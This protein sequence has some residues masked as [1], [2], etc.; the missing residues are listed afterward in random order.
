MTRRLLVG[1]LLLLA[2][3]LPAVVAA[4]APASDLPI[5]PE[6]APFRSSGRTLVVSPDGPYRSPS[7]ALAAA[8]SGDT[9]EV[10]GGT[11][12]EH[13]EVK[14]AIRLVGV[15]W[16][17]LDGGGRGS[18]LTLLAPRVE[19]TGFQIRGTGD[20]PSTEDAA[21]TV[22]APGASIHENRI[23]EA[24]FGIYLRQADHSQVIGNEITGM[25]VDLGLRGDAI[26]LWYSPV[27]TVANNRVEGGRDVI[28]WFSDQAVVRENT[29]SHS[30]YGLHFMWS[31]DGT[32]EGNRLEENSV[33][34]FVMYSSRVV[35]RQ[36]L[37][38]E[39]RG[40]SGYGLALKDSEHLTVEQNWIAGNRVGLYLDN[41]PYS[42]DASNRFTL[43]V[44]AG[45]EVGLLAMP[46][47]HDNQFA[48]NDFI[49]NA[50]QVQLTTGG[51][52]GPNTWAE[53]GLG[54]FWSDYA[55]YDGNGD[56][57]GD[58]PYQ[59]VS[60]FDELV[61]HQELLRWFRHSPAA[62]AVDLAARA[63]P[64]VAPEP[65]LTDPAPSVS[66]YRA[67]GYLP[68]DTATDSRGPSLAVVSGGMLGA[69]AL[70]GAALLRAGPHRRRGVAR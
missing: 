68:S 69:A 61:S 58:M 14:V 44:V 9:V 53:E 17:V 26:R 25:K 24:L 66:P 60:L 4:A 18:V 8:G 7:A 40:P 29:I 31:G 46:S 54:N 5:P 57:I 65:R 62:T 28:V 50:E 33:G 34:L 59:P 45:N 47:T 12:R 37:L 67:G 48:R 6:P 13:L 38:R 55:G 2:L 39:S 35:V 63:F 27:C 52:L 10:R 1:L 15:D 56:G 49:D 19:V 11:Y 21:I 41:S 30:R 23:S 42:A 51:S 43:N 32:V 36:N 3:L 70:L 20:N 16:P 64:A 22:R